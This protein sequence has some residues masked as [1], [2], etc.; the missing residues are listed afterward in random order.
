MNT[1]Q[2]HVPIAVNKA[3][4]SFTGHLN[5]VKVHLKNFCAVLHWHIRWLATHDIKDFNQLWVRWIN[6]RKNVRTQWDVSL[7]Q[8]LNSQTLVFWRRH[9]FALVGVNVKILWGIDQGEILCSLN[10]KENN[11]FDV[12]NEGW[13]PVHGTV[14]IALGGCADDEMVMLHSHID[15]SL[16]E[17]QVVVHFMEA[18]IDTNS[19]LWVQYRF[20]MSPL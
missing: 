12:K 20:D 11:V 3:H 8:E 7:V 15:N 17:I 18:V 13:T 5:L 16:S 4:F 14:D 10:D 1:G 2:K 9:K 19:V 6:H